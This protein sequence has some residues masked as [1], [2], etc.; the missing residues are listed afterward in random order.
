MNN[1]VSI[2]RQLM[3]LLL[4]FV[5]LG[6]AYAGP[7]P[8]PTDWLPQF[9][10]ISFD[11][12]DVVFGDGYSQI[13]LLNR[14]FGNL[15]GAQL[16]NFVEKQNSYVPKVAACSIPDAVLSK[17]PSQYRPAEIWLCDLPH[18]IW[19]ATAGYCGESDDEPDVNQGHLFSY[20]PASGAI[21]QYPGFL[22]ECSE[23]A[24]LVQIN[25]L[26]VGMT[27]F[28]SEYS[29]SAGNVV[30]LDLANSKAP[31]KVLRNPHA[32]GA[33]VGISPY[34]KQCDCL[35][36][37]TEKGIERLVINSGQWEQ[38][39]FDYEITPD[40]KFT[41]T[42]SPKQPNEEHMWLGR[43]L[44]NFPIEDLRGF[45]KAWSQSPVLVNSD[46]RLRASSFLL[47]YYIAAIERTKDW[48]K[49]WTYSE[50]MRLVA[51]HQ[52]P[53]SK[54]A[55]RAFI[56]RMLQQPTRLSRKGEVMS[57]A[58]RLG[59]D[60][61]S[62][63]SAYFNDLLTEYFS[64]SKT[65]YSHEKDVV[66]YA[67]EHP[68]YLPKLRDYYQTHTIAIEIEDSFLDTAKAYRMWQGYS[69]M[70]S[71]IDAGL[72]RMK[73]RFDL[74]DMCAL[75]ETPRDEKKLLAILQARLETDAQAKL[76]N[77]PG[78]G[79]HNCVNASFYWINYGGPD[80]VRRRI[81]LML[82]TAAEH[83]EYSLIIFEALNRKYSTSS[84]DIDEWR[85]WWNSYTP[86]TNSLP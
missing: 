82:A 40:N 81:D 34:D 44:Y 1:S 52:D 77:E 51:L 66:R 58:K 21:T 6:S 61:K 8:T 42:L 56:E 57:A 46:S 78:R 16:N 22:P 12:D 27:Y 2:L 11:G 26:L 73:H 9:S 45:S 43:T 55:A 28:Q 60:A 25:N 64:G 29:Q 72:K 33:I 76:T 35:W 13:R 23:L 70:A 41:L 80:Q 10:K 3:L 75:N 14:Q 74:F 39:Y 85:R 67:F 30:I 32:T 7:D 53:D 48:E 69:V 59:V 36:F 63:E 68:E 4:L 62:L 5:F 83:K 31:P 18:R 84:K 47:P 86:P 71:T 54:P 38:R 24:G 17:Y 49:D 15:L 19:Y 79:E 50:L 65:K 20:S 37:A